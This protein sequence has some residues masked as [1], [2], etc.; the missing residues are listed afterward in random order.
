MDKYRRKGVG[1]ALM[2]QVISYAREQKKKRKPLKKLVL[3]C[4]T[5]QPAGWDL[6]NRSG[7]KEVEKTSVTSFVRTIY[8]YKM[9]L[10][11]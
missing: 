6:F 10:E 9:E 1:K 8:D 7:W 5:Y 3:T 2:D 4:T 11:L